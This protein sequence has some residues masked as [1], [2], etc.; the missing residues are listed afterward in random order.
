MVTLFIPLETRPGE[1]RIALDPGT[2]QTLGSK[3]GVKVRVQ[4]GAGAAAGFR[5]AAFTDAGAEIV[6]DAAS[7]C[8]GADLVA[9]VAPPD[10]GGPGIAALGRGVVL[11]TSVQPSVETELVAALEAS[12]V[13]LLSTD[14]IP[15]ISRAQSMDVLSSQATVAGYHAVLLAATALPRLFPLLMT[16]AGTIKPARVLVMGA[17]VAGLQAI[18]T[19]RRLGAV[20]EATDIREAAK[21]EVESLGARFVDTTGGQ[22]RE[23]E[24]GYARASTDDEISAQQAVLAEHV[25]GSDVVI[26]TANVPG[27]KAPVLVTEDMVAA[28]R[29][30]SV[31]V[32]MAVG[33]GGNCPLSVAGKS[34]T[35]EGGVTII[36]EPNLPAQVPADASAM[37]GRNL[38][39]LLKLLLDDEGALAPDWDDEILAGCCVTRQGQ[40]T[41]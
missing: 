38:L 32:D 27:R 13:T 31:I 11:I 22:D 19:A 18:A 14:L 30:G 2:V 29:P 33:S 7:G 40:A 34:V 23:G 9:S 36:G 6:P 17:G 37:L 20:V 10:L 26:T 16:A 15:R 41:T 39:D 5:D 12:G 21:T 8:A 4:S 3:L 24:G 28:M 35:T 1:S 25:A